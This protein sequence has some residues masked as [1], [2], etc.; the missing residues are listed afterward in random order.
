[1]VHRVFTLYAIRVYLTR[2][3]YLVNGVKKW[4]SSSVYYLLGL[5]SRLVTSVPYLKGDAP[6]LLDEF[7]PKITEG[8]ITSRFDS[9]QVLSQMMFLIVV[10]FHF[11]I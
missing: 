4:A 5:W 8:F 7:V 6:S 1:M 3:C 2:I 11:P 9:V 10:L